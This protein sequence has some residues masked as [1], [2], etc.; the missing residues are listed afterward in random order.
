[1]ADEVY[2][3]A[4]AQNHAM[5]S[6]I[7]WQCLYKAILTKF[8]TSVGRNNAAKIPVMIANVTEAAFVFLNSST[9]GVEP[10]KWAVLFSTS[11]CVPL[12]PGKRGNNKI[13][14]RLKEVKRSNRANY[15]QFWQVAVRKTKTD[16]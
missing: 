5:L 10:S 12:P 14:A 6:H 9:D 15:P 2:D 13:R 3:K 16:G 4:A 8:T 11:K 7:L 1:M